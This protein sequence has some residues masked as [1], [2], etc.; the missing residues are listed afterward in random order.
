MAAHNVVCLDCGKQ[1]DINKKGGAYSKDL[2]RYLC[3][4]CMKKRKAAAKEKNGIYCQG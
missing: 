3:R 4:S 2:G 1:F